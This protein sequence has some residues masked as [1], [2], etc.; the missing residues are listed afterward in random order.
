AGT[1][2]SFSVT[3][4]GTGLSYQWRKGGANIGGATASTYTIASPVAGDA[5]SYDVVVSGT[6]TPS[7]TSSSV[8]LTINALPAIT[9][10]PTNQT[11]CAGTSVSFSVTAT[12]T[13]LSYQW[14]KGG[15][16]IGGA[17]ASTYTIVSP[18]AGD[19]GSYDVVVS[20]TCTPSVTSSSVTLTVDAAP[21]ITVQPTNQTTCAGTSVSFSVTATGT[22][23]SYQWRKGGVNIG[24][25]TASTY[26]IAS[27]VVG[28]AGSYDVVVSGTCVPS[29][30]SSSATLTV[31]TAPAITTQPTSQTVCAGS[32]VSFSVVATGTGL[33]YQ[34]RK[35][36]VN[37]GG[38]T[39]PTY[40]IGS[41]VSGDADNYDVMIVGTCLPSITS[42]S[43]TLTVN[44]APSIT[45]QPTN[46]TT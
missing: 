41:V 2:V 37:I 24:G 45:V 6:C 16:N 5:G 7:V 21:V 19:A 34:W 22:G 38:A 3:A 4:T 39:G 14:R 10:Q 44:T 11:T 42:A 31:N 13:G 25:A 26:T 35:G 43:A 18:V 40:I 9:V 27:P 23:L 46:Q 36:G 30:T 8:T 1:S 15:A 12:G 28:D 20:G 33:T 17:T 29:V 32:S